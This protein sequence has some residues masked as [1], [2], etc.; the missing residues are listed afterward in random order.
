MVLYAGL[1]V[2]PHALF[3]YRRM[4][5]CYRCGATIDAEGGVFRG[6]VCPSCGADAR[7]CKNCTFY[8]PGKH[9]DCKETVPEE[10]RD[11]ERAN[12]CD[13]FRPSTAAATTTNSYEQKRAGARSAFDSLFGQIET[14]GDDDRDT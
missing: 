9:W 1:V 7:V 2:T 10:V 8:A 13:Y 5:T 11:K 12:F 3:Y 14:S 6:T 4:A